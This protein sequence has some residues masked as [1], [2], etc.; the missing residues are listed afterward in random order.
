ML[1]ESQL[2]GPSSA[3]RLWLVGA[4]Y[5]ALLLAGVS[6]NIFLII[7]FRSHPIPWRQRVEAL[8]HR[9]WRWQ[10]LRQLTLFLLLMQLA[11]IG[12]NRFL[13]RFSAHRDPEHIVTVWI[14]AQSVA[15]HLAGLL[16]LCL[17]L[18]RRRLAWQTAFGMRPE[19]LWLRFGQGLAGYIAVMPILFFAALASYLVLA[20]FDYPTSIQE[21]ARFLASSHPLWLQIYLV[22]LTVI[23]APGFEEALFRG[24]AFPILARRLGLGPAIILSSLIFAAIHFHLPSFVPLFIVA[25]GFSLVYLY[26]GSLLTPIV[27]HGLFNGVN[28]ALLLLLDGAAV[29]PT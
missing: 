29:G 2:F 9:P 11:V 21:V 28:L 12:I 15:F 8:Q 26:S 16:A 27:M 19:R 20:H 3:H 23:V 1:T 17:L 10:E 5:A 22:L 14:V 18:H 7:R 4:A 13:F 25:T 24:V 6:I